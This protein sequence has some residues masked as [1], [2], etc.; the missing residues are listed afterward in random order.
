MLV[1]EETAERRIL[2]KGAVVCRLEVVFAGMVKVIVENTSPD[3]L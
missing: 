1:P 2:H 3:L